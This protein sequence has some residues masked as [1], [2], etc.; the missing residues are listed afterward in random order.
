MLMIIVFSVCTQKSPKRTFIYF[1]PW[2]CKIKWIIIFDISL[3]NAQPTSLNIYFILNTQETTI[4]HENYTIHNN[5]Y[6]V[7]VQEIS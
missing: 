1:L 5:L 3:I 6:T 2:M 4:Q 7:Y